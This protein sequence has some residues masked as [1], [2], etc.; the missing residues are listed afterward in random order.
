MISSSPSPWSRS[1]PPRVPR[2]VL[3]LRSQSRS[4]SPSRS[5]SPSAVL[6]A[7][8]SSSSHPPRLQANAF[9]RNAATGPREYGCEPREQERAVRSISSR[10]DARVRSDRRRGGPRNQSPPRVR[11][12]RGT[13]PPPATRAPIRTCASPLAVPS[14]R[15]TPTS[16]MFAANRMDERP[17]RRSLRGRVPYR[18]AERPARRDCATAAESKARAIRRARSRRRRIRP[19]DGD[20]RNHRA[21]G[22]EREKRRARG[23]VRRLERERDGAGGNGAVRPPPPSASPKRPCL[24]AP[25]SSGGSRTAR[26]RRRID[27]RGNARLETAAG[28]GDRS[29]K[30]TRER[31]GGG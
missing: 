8:L 21:G 25:G 9:S 16:V 3:V 6:S 13:P 15:P 26:A 29:T 7:A 27:S 30:T 2:R 23:R 22:L 31:R 11:P 14:N 28:P 1:P 10:R 19:D 5:H 24:A 4:Q 12:G 18:S 17:A 20:G